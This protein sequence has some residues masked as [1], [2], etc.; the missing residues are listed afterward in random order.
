MVPHHQRDGPYLIISICF[1][2]TH[3][4]F[5]SRLSAPSLLGSLDQARRRRAHCA[6][7]IL[8]PE[9]LRALVE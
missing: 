6:G 9:M 4:F 2:S 8:T 3:R 7:Q 5:L 1:F